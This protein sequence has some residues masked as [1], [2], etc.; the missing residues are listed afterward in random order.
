MSGK[1]NLASGKTANSTGEG[2]KLYRKGLTGRG[3]TGEEVLHG[4]TDEQKEEG[5]GD[6]GGDLVFAN[7]SVY[8]GAEDEEVY[9]ADVYVS[10]GRIERIVRSDDLS[11][12]FR[13][14]K[15][16]KTDLTALETGEK[17]EKDGQERHAADIP[18]PLPPPWSIDKVVQRIDC[19]GLT[20]C[21][22]F[23]DLHAHSDL[24][25]LTKPDHLPK[26]SQG[27][28]VSHLVFKYSPQTEVIGQDGLSY[29]PIKTSDQL[30][31]IRTQI[32]GWNGNPS[33]EEIE[34]LKARGLEGLFEWTD[35][36]GFLGCLGKNGTAVNVAML[37]PQVSV[38]LIGF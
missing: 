27:V 13:T 38:L 35:V 7:V 18:S 34:Q 23:I 21:P 15:P 29:A 36:D 31:S 2:S 37:V 6:E 9:T 33:T 30:L 25:L 17:D 5:E 26:V 32:S 14:N 16:S 10:K 11:S 24:Y 22:G 3:E 8:S 1:A 20:L 28:T 4:D 12:G 19:S